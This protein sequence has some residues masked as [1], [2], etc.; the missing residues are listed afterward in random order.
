[1]MTQAEIYQKWKREVKEDEKLMDWFKKR[2]CLSP[3]WKKLVL[4]EYRKRV[5]EKVDFT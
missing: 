5:Y 1:M 4:E 3:M 2:K